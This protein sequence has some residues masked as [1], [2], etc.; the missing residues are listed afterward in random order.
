MNLTVE[1]A[2][3]IYPLNKGK[4]VAGQS[5]LQ[6]VIRSVNVMDAPDI[7]SWL[8]HKEI[9]FTTAFIFKGYPEAATDLIRRL[10]AGGCSALGIKLG[11]YWTEIPEHL[12]READELGFPL[13]ELPYEYTFSDMMK[14]LYTTSLGEEMKGLS[15]ILNKQK[16]LIHLA[17]SQSSEQ[18]IYTNLFKILDYPIVIM[19][20]K[21]Y[22]LFNTTDWDESFWRMRMKGYLATKWTGFRGTRCYQVPLQQNEVLYG[23][24]MIVVGENVVPKDEEWLFVQAGELLTRYMVRKKQLGE[25]E[26]D[27][28][29]TDVILYLKN[30]IPLAVLLSSL[31]KHGLVLPFDKYRCVLTEVGNQEVDTFWDIHEKLEFSPELQ[32]YKG[33]HFPMG[34]AILS[35]Y[36]VL[37]SPEGQNDT[38]GESLVSVINGQNSERIRANFYI[39]RIKKQ[40][41]FLQEAYEECLQTKQTVKKAELLG[42]IFYDEDLEIYRLLQYIPDDVLGSY[43]EKF[44]APLQNS[45][46]MIRTLEMFLEYDGQINEV[47]KKLFVHRNTIAY[48]MEKINSLLGIEFRNYNDI[49]KLKMVFWYYRKNKNEYKFK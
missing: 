17:L 18:D 34:Q 20:R 44:L 22:L 25:G 24:L 11:R 45:E 14:G 40:A 9:L 16:S 10:H 26:Q 47:A 21:G 8:K 23:Y 48:R 46:E 13:I 36:P 5:G 2:L 7:V 37:S 27:E 41:S 6:R 30:R 35:I 31:D 29:V 42:S 39:S 49:V 19:S 15:L 38:L 12:V 33:F 1:Q 32:S 28:C 4:L 3:S 43:S